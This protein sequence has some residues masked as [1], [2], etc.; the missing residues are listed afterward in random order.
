MECCSL[1]VMAELLLEPAYSS[2]RKHRSC[3]IIW[4]KPSQNLSVVACAVY[5]FPMASPQTWRRSTF[6][7]NSLQSPIHHKAIHVE[8]CSRQTSPVSRDQA[9]P[10]TSHSTEGVSRKFNAKHACSGEGPGLGRD[11]KPNPYNDSFLGE[12]AA[13]KQILV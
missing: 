11:R 12:Y 2:Q 9:K 8:V 10:D 5:Y 6:F 4:G 7:W 13:H 1:E 3:L